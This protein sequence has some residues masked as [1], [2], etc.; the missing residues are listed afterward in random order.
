LSTVAPHSGFN[1]H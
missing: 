1:F